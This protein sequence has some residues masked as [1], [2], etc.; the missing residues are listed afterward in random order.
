M[1]ASITHKP[2]FNALRCGFDLR[3]RTGRN[4]ADRISV[5]ELSSA[6]N[7]EIIRSAD[8]AV[9][10]VEVLDARPRIVLA[11]GLTQ[12]ESRIQ[13]A[14]GLARIALR[15]GACDIPRRLHDA[16]G[17][18]LEFCYALLVPAHKVR[19]SATAL[20]VPEWFLRNAVV[21]LRNNPEVIG[22]SPLKQAA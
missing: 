6:A 13:A 7:V 8:A 5:D 15:R 22:P 18:E 16:G 1:S 12:V 17:P 20:A 19:L 11:A 14:I 4:E 21:V 2:V 3:I 9:S 10:K